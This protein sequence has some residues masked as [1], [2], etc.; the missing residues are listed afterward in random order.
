MIGMGFSDETRVSMALQVTGG[1]I[2]HAV[3]YYLSNA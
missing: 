1:D 2:D 3:N